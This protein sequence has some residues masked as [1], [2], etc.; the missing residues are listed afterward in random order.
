VRT[1]RRRTPNFRRFIIT[2]TLL[3]F[4]VGA[5]IAVAGD[6]APDYSAGSQIGFFGVLFGALGALLSALFAV[7]LDRRP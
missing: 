5:V 1:T 6:S 3:G 7:L 2:G 4:V